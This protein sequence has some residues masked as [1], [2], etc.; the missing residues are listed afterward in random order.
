FK[1]EERPTVVPCPSEG[2]EKEAEYHM[3]TPAYFKIKF[4]QNGRVGFK[5]DMGGGKQFRRSA[6]R[7]QHEHILG[8]RT[9]AD[10]RKMGNAKSEGVYTK[11]FG[12]AVKE[13][14]TEQAA[15]K[16]HA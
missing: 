4:D 3:S 12:R 11:E 16:L 7:E 9:N 2:C 13:K 14:Q 15:Q 1:S 10:I 6:T 5:Y 8:S